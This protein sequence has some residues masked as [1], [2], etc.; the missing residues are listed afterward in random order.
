MMVVSQW[1]TMLWS[2]GYGW[3][4]GC[5]CFLCYLLLHFIRP[6]DRELRW[7]RYGAV[8]TI[9]IVLLGVFAMGYVLHA[10]GGLRGELP[11]LV[12]LISGVAVLSTALCG[13]QHDKKRT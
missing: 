1:E 12:A 4:T 8:A 5:T 2:I 6:Q 10:V 9:P 3:L 13:L 7:L 11:A